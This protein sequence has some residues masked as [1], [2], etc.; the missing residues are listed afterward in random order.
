MSSR[1]RSTSSAASTSPARS[2]RVAWKLSPPEPP[3]PRS[4]NRNEATPAPARWLASTAN[5]RKRATPAETES[6]SCAPLPLIR[7]TPGCG[8]SPEG[9]VNSPARTMSPLEKTTSVRRNDAA[10]PSSPG[11]SKRCIQKVSIMPAWVNSP[12]ITPSI[13]SPSQT[14]S[15]SGES[16]SKWRRPASSTTFDSGKP[17]TPWMSTVPRR[18]SPDA[19][20]TTA[21]GRSVGPAIE[22]PPSQRPSR[23]ADPTPV[24]PAASGA[25]G[26]AG[27][28]TG[29][30]VAGVTSTA[31]TGS[32]G[33]GVSAELAAVSS[34]TSGAIGSAGG[35]GSTGGSAGGVVAGVASAVAAGAGAGPGVGAA[36]EEDGS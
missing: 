32:G 19:V 3:T 13:T 18:P 8:P 17:G 29:W 15:P 10:S 1:E 4:S 2:W 5:S 23:S 24:A 36:S 33:A 21:N 22:I 9:N 7:T 16:S 28:C 14:A 25:S 20:R 11:S 27:S 30:L 31:S 12:S 6:L 35:V 34:T 26:S